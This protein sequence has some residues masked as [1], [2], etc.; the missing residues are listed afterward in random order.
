MTATVERALLRPSARTAQQIFRAV[1]DALARPGTVV[2]L[3]PVPGFAAALGP[4]L[5]LADPDTPVCV[6]GADPTAAAT[7]TA[8]PVVDPAAARLVAALRPV[9]V[10]ELAALRTGTA[11]APEDAALVALAVPALHGGPTHPLAGPGT[12]AGAR[13]AVA[14]LPDGWVTAR[15]AAVFPAG[16]DLLFVDPDGGC[17]GLPRSTYLGSTRLGSTRLG[18]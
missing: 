13:L 8:A 14:G 3:P 7:A 15:A 18:G 2:R 10:A 11:A 9:T 1:L 6:L 17:V 4:L 12:G 5:A 16:V